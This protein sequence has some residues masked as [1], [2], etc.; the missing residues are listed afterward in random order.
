MRHT[1]LFLIV[2]LLLF[3][4]VEVVAQSW[5]KKAA[6]SVFTL[7]TF[8]DSGTLLGSSY[9]F[10]VGEQGQCISS[11]EPFRGAY[12]ATVID[13]AGKEY[14][15]ELMLGANETYD[16]AKFRVQ[17]KKTQPVSVAT[18]DGEAGQTV[19]LLPYLCQ[20]NAVEGVL[21]KAE[22]VG[23][24]YAYYT[25][26]VAMPADGVGLPLMTADGQVLGVMQKPSSA[27]DTIGYAVS[28]RFADSLKINGLSINDA[29]LRAT[30]IKK[31]LPDDVSQAL[32]TL[33][34]APSALDS[35]AFVQLVD[36]FIAKFPTE[37]EGYITRAQLAADQGRYAEADRDMG[38]AI[39]VGAKPDEAHYS[40]SRMIYQKNIYKPQDDYATWTL[41]M[42]MTEAQTAYGLNPLPVYQ[43][44]QAYVL[45]AQ[46]KY[47]EA[48]AIYDQLFSSALRSANL[49][50]EASQCHLM[51]ADTL[52]QLALLD[53][54]VALYSRPYLREAA[55]VIMTR[56]QA[57]LAAGKY[58]DAVADFNDYEQLLPT[59]VNDS[60]YY[61][62]HQ[63]EV[64][65]RLFQQ[66][67]NDI[68]KAIQ[69]NPDEELYYAEKA[70]LEVRVG[71]YDEAIATATECIGV[72]PQYSDGYL[73]LGLAQCLKGD[74]TAGVANLR[75]AKELGDDQA[76]GLIER[77]GQ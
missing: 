71:L 76:D 47:A 15:V 35:S 52:G 67:L 66:A 57:R 12:S 8:D 60:F 5:V 13:A 27:A 14:P 22:T 9:G 69:M 41:D 7:K 32:L 70:S 53:S 51:M 63:A 3:G 37:Q 16:V 74:K 17:A 48:S 19:W 72:N 62:R 6:K 77:Y 55:P 59:R 28:A 34:V 61:A 10:F 25:A 75:K 21:R 50:I 26:L 36:D 31:D 18:Q 43:Q 58:R 1:P 4:S 65:G 2:I 33:F 64:N 54:A 49:F 68:A 29:T 40:Y 73:F 56:A 44:Q 42:A 24:G 45:Y 20:K 39:S 30:H 38:Q 23:T 11:F 46:Q